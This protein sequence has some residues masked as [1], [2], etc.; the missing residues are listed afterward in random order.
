[1]RYVFALATAAI[2][3]GLR[4][5]LTPLTGMGASFVLFLGATLVTSLLAGPGPGLLTLLVSIPLAAFGFVIPAGATPTQAAF[6]SLIFGVD[7]LIILYVSSRLRR[8]RARVQRSA[9]QFRD[10][11]ER[12]PVGV[13]S[14]SAGQVA[15]ANGTLARLLGYDDAK[16]LVGR[17]VGDL[18]GRGFPPIDERAQEVH[19]LRRDGS[20][21]SVEC[22]GFP[23]E[24]E[25]KAGL[26]VV[27]HDL[28]ERKRAEGEQR[29]L[30]E[31]G[32]VLGASLDYERTMESVAQL[33]V[34]DFADWC[35]VDIF[36]R[37]NEPRLKVVSADPAKAALCAQLERVPIDRSRPYLAREAIESRR[38]QLLE[39]LTDADLVRAAQSP[40]HL[41]ALRTFAP[42][43]LMVVP[44][45]SRDQLLGTL[46][47][48]SSTPERRYTR[49]DLRMART[50]AE[51][52]ATA[53]ENARL[54]RKAMDASKLRDQ[55]LGVVA[56][57]LRNPLSS[58]LLQASALQR[59]HAPERRN[60]R[61]R[62]AI[63]QAATRMNHLIQDL[64]DVAVVEAG[65]L[66]LQQALV[67]IEGLL[68]EAVQMQR[69]LA[70]AESLEINLQM[71]GNLP[72][73][74][75]DRQRLLQVLEN[76]IG[77]AIKFTD[78]GGRIEVGATPRADGVLCWVSDSGCGI[79]AEDLPHVFERFWQASAHAGRYGAGLGLPISK[80]I[81]DAHGG[82]IWAQSTVD[83]GTTFFFQLP[84]AAQA[85]VEVP[86]SVEL[87][88]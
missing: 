34:H 42:K 71:G 52:A 66:K 84:S 40:E 24:L 15:Y 43:S 26:V 36:E 57:D 14:S 68:S 49:A 37:G 62:E 87:P 1:M 70:S 59:R 31:A 81:I 45:L 35:V 16:G 8:G 32:T 64:L 2:A 74:W 39:G 10:L 20:P 6:Q 22:A 48:V 30:A 80:G 50:L 60:P 79:S 44:L 73:L 63:V 18:L 28:T 23:A 61:G 47:F 13:F 19:M 27:V 38:A 54:Y 78:S 69:P 33:V 76:L 56:H 4:E 5:A 72:L 85:G 82:R 3:F 51:R 9:E 86:E 29:L 75:G 41:E 83:R 7:G 88:H 11:V 17:P 65:Q 77:N 25:G 58:I 55:V 67:P 21:C 46:I 12:L 53:I